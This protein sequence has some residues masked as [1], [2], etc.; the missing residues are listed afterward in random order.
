MP[1]DE[2][3][4]RIVADGSGVATECDAAAKSVE[5]LGESAESNS[6]KMERMGKA[7]VHVEAHMVGH[8]IPGMGRMTRSLAMLGESAVGVTP[9]LV[10][11]IPVAAIAAGVLIMEKME[12]AQLKA[13]KA[14]TELTVESAKLDDKIMEEKEHL[15]TLVE[16]PM[17]G[18]IEKAKDYGKTVS[19]SESVLKSFDKELE[20]HTT[21]WAVY[22]QRV[23][24]ATDM[25][26][27]FVKAGG[28]T[29]GIAA[30]ASIGQGMSDKELEVRIEK[31]EAAYP[32]V[33]QT[34]QKLKALQGLMMELSTA[35]GPQA[36]QQMAALS[37]TMLQVSKVAEDERLKAQIHHAE[38]H[39]DELKNAA[40][41]I[42][43]EKSAVEM[44]KVG[45]D[46]K[47][48]NA[49][50]ANK[51]LAENDKLR[52]AQAEDV[53]QKTVLSATQVMNAKLQANE[54]EAKSAHDLAMLKI[55]AAEDEGR[56]A[57][58]QI[59]K[60]RTAKLAALAGDDAETRTRK[61]VE[62]NR[63][64]DDQI[65][66]SRAKTAG[67]IAKLNAEDVAATQIAAD[68][69]QEIVLSGEKEITT[70]TIKEE[71][72]RINKQFALTQKQTAEQLKLAQDMQKAA[73][74]KLFISG[75][76]EIGVL[77]NA[78]SQMDVLIAKRSE[79]VAAHPEEQNLQNELETM[80][81]DRQD[82]A[83]K[84]AEID[85]QIAQHNAATL[86]RMT[87]AFNGNIM[88]WLK[89][90]EKFG[91][92]MMKTWLN[93]AGS[94]IQNLMKMGEQYIM[95]TI[96]EE[97]K[98]REQIF[99][100]AGVAASKAMGAV[101]PP[102]NFPLA[103]AAF[104]ATAAFASFAQGGIMEQD[105]GAILHRNE[106]VLPP[107][108]SDFI[109]NAAKNATPAVSEESSNFNLTQNIHA[110]D[111]NGV[112]DVLKQH[113]DLMFAMWKEQMRS[114]NV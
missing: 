105:G 12:E 11:L 19:E 101:P 25:V 17:A 42:Y 110:I 64:M 41:S 82:Y 30:A 45:W 27:A 49:E 94:A 54:N 75:G 14:S 56:V 66:I 20:A 69:R 29:A 36:A 16:G 44:N 48:A 96:L 73:P 5:D 78:I 2:I 1:D 6:S 28:G 99:H 104:A 60:E 85:V 38:I 3:K 40:E 35:G 111:A 13:A 46:T 37:D 31:I 90:D 98:A 39:K 61:S 9:L 79:L 88:Q 53:V 84:V 80:I 77:T 108:L 55:A 58:E 74:G 67:E 87:A 107:H 100:N 63:Q 81:T 51:V 47:V 95:Y 21:T 57:I 15:T 23:Q 92:A 10:G 76:A 4:V 103:V 113:S 102:L 43:V 22:V 18:A 33:E 32:R 52:E 26:V 97:T 50:A 71:E 114:R 59:N 86:D 93:I 8:M 109:Q 7:M 72:D 24:R 62:I 106:M 112:A 70:L 91:Q 89:G 83:D 34:T 65:A 68:K